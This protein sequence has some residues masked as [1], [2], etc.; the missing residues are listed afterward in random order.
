MHSTL[1]F[2][3]RE[4]SDSAVS[5]E[6]RGWVISSSTDRSVLDELGADLDAL[7]AEV[8]APICARRL[9][10][11]VWLRSCLEF[12]PWVISVREGGTLAGVAMFAERRRA[13]HREIVALGHGSSDYARLPVR[14]DDAARV[15]ADAV[16]DALDR[17]RS[18]WR[19]RFDQLPSSDPVAVHLV[20]R[21]AHAAIEPGDASPRLVLHGD[22]PLDA[23]MSAKTRQSLR[24][25]RNRLDKLD[26][27]YA[28]RI[29]RGPGVCAQLDDIERVHR[30]R[31]RA[32]GRDSDLDHPSQGRFWHEVLSAY[33]AR[34][35]V[36]IGRLQI[37]GELAAY[38][39]SFLDGSSYRLWDTRIDPARAFVS[40]GRVL[41]ADLIERLRAEG[42]WSEFDFMRGE[43]DYKRRMSDD[44]VP[45]ENLRAWSSAALRRLERRFRGVRDRLRGGA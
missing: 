31:D 25:A 36:E 18:P 27:G 1:L 16:G 29:D 17:R 8:D 10:L 14:S 22:R 40:P 15:L 41:L 32:L 43:E 4:G 33:G 21:L 5:T 28:V 45:A 39:V 13:G 44:A 20:E 19:L 24:T 2:L 38:T 34:S 26:G 11:T 3:A 23:V 12:S 9:W 30:R 7:L 35:E 37:A 6:T 42:A